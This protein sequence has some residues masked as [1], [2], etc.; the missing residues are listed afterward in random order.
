M[1]FKFSINYFNF[2]VRINQNEI[3]TKSFFEICFGNYKSKYI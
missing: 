2:F 1:D 3:N